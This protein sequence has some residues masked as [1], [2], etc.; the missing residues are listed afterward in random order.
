MTKRSSNQVDNPIFARVFH[1]V[2][3]PGEGERIRGCRRA[4][5]DG[6]VGHVVEVG[7]GDGANFA[8]YPESVERVSALEPE[9]YLRARAARAAQAASVSV[10]VE[11][12]PADR[13][14]AEDESVDAVVF[15]LVLCTVPDP[16]A[17]LAEARRVLRP[18]GQ[19]RVFEHVIAE[20]PIPRAFQRAAQATVWPRLFGGCHPARDTLAT[21]RQAGFD[22]SQLRRFTLHPGGAS[23][24]M[25]VVLGSATARSGPAA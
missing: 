5:L 13:L 16:A 18:D 9:P 15:S 19:I 22:T 17:A 21:I 12:A 14:P 24:P 25:P 10:R 7:A 3:R 8:L 4:T 11:A 1:H 6:L 23:P 2:L 20:R